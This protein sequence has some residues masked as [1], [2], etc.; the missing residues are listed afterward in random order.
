MDEKLSGAAK[1]VEVPDGPR[2]MASQCG[3]QAKQEVPASSAQT[4]PAVPVGVSRVDTARFACGVQTFIARIVMVV[5]ALVLL[6]AFFLPWGSANSAYRE[7]A[8]QMPGLMFY[9]PAGLTVA[10][11]ADLS[12]LEYAQA[13]AALGGAWLIVTIVIYVT[14]GLSALALLLAALGKPIGSAVMG[15]LCVAASR[16][17][18][19][20]FTDR[21]VLPSG[22]HDWG[23]AQML[24]LVAGVVLL[25]A[26]V[27]MVVA[28]RRA[29]V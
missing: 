12:L 19:W 4:P 9:E 2:H 1:S 21:A 14:A 25:A 15:L 23:I 6:G 24:Y 13:Y 8:T 27:W 29:R 5:A 10:D 28:R 16:V 17:L 11:A 3:A 26:A 18:V 20:D 7:A 22:T